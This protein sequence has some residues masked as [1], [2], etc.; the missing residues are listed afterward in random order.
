MFH[1]LEE[2]LIVAWLDD[3]AVVI[4]TMVRPLR[5]FKLLVGSVYILSNYYNSLVWDLRPSLFL[6]S[7]VGIEFGI[8]RRRSIV[9]SV[10][11]HEEASEL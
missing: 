10:R 4:E 9:L 2:A 8:R 5:I 7:R 11:L 1:H 3:D 6:Q